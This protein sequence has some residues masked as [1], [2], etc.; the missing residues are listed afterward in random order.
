MALYAREGDRDGG[1]SVSIHRR[2]AKRDASERE[3]VEMLEA[4]GWRVLKVSVKDGPDLI[5][6]RTAYLQGTGCLSPTGS[7]TIAIEVKSGKAKLR[8]GQAKWMADWP[9]EKAV[10]RS[11]EDVKE[12]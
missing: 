7:R 9:G 10:L 6:S 1:V 11:A 8:E 2:A 5:I 3:I 12:L 4:C